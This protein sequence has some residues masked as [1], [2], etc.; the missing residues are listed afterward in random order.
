M[1]T[2]TKKTL[3]FLFTFVLLATS[4]LA[5]YTANYTSDDMD[6][7]LIDTL[8]HGGVKIIG[9][10]SVIIIFTLLIMFVRAI[11]KR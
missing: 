10:L 4:V 1:E 5:T 2:K 8:A 3:L 6:D 7:I 11:K 9:L